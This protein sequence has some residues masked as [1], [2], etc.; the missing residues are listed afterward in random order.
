MHDERRAWGGARVRTSMGMEW[1]HQGGYSVTFCSGA[2]GGPDGPPSAELLALLRNRRVLVVTTP[3]AWRLH[4]TDRFPAAA[5]LAGAEV[6]TFV[7]PLDE[8]TKTM[9]AVLDV[10]RRAEEFGLGRGDLL[11]AFGGGLVCDVVTVAASQL[12]R[13]M[14]Y[15]CLPTTLVGQIDAGIGLKGGVNLDGA[16]NRLGTF[17]A[18]EAVVSDPGW[19]L[20]LDDRAMRSGLAE[21]VKVGISRDADL[22]RAIETSGPELLASRFAAPPLTA[23]RVLASAAAAMLDELALT[24]FEDHRQPRL[25]DFGHS[26]SPTLERASGY[27]ITHGEAVGVDMALST[28]IAVELGRLDRADADAIQSLLAALG[29]DRSTPWCSEE[30]VRDGFEL[31]RRQRSGALNLVI[32]VGIGKADFVDD[33]TDDVLA[34]ALCRVRESQAG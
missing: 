7:V 22:F 34:G 2:L 30:L 26:Y 1:A 11:V 17:H 32:P 13:G 27:A 4:G 29:L 10:S 6:D 25:M 15:A 5:H 31:T 21:I 14:P 9:S 18:P 3:N 33:V 16:K 12:H 8:G 20:T 24:P 28:E 23:Q 19:L